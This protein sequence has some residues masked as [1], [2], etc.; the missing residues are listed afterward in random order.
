MILASYPYKREVRGH[1]KPERILL[2]EQFAFPFLYYPTAF[3]QKVDG[4]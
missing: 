1:D 3:G 2:P 4:T